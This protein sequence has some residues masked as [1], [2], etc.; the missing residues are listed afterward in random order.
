MLILTRKV[1]ESIII[2]S[3]IKVTVISIDGGQI[4]LGIDAPKEVIV[5][6]EE[7]YQR[8]VEEN[9]LAVTASP[10][11]LKKIA[12]DWKSAHQENEDK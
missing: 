5:H 9:K 4:R 8:I 2:D 1:G 11:D 3:N 7:V 12:E 6:R 10:T